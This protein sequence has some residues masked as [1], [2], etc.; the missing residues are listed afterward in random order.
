M[1]LP[2]SRTW[3]T[4]VVLLGLVAWAGPLTAA[5]QDA[6]KAKEVRRAIGVLE[7]PDAEEARRTSAAMTLADLGADAK[8]AVPALVVALKDKSPDTRLWAAVAL[9][10][11]DPKRGKDEMAVVVA[12]FDD[13]AAPL[14]PLGFL[15]FAQLRPANKDVVSGLLAL[16]KHKNLQAN[17]SGRIAMRNVG[18]AARD[19]LPLLEEALMDRQVLARVFAAAALARIDPARRAKAAPV[20]EAAL[21]DKDLD[22]RFEAA[23]ALAEIDPVRADRASAALLPALED[24]S[25]DTR[26]RVAEAIL[27]FDPPRRKDLLAALLA[28]VKEADKPDRLRALS[29]LAQMG[30]AAEDAKKT[31][32]SLLKSKEPEIGEAAAEALIRL[33]PDRART[34]FPSLLEHRSRQNPGSA[35]ADILRL[36]DGLEELSKDAGKD[37][38]KEWVDSLIEQLTQKEMRRDRDLIRLDALMRLAV[39]GPKAKDAVPALLQTLREETPLLRNQ[40]VHVL[41]GMG[42]AAREAVPVLLKVTKDRD[43][44]PLDVREAAAAAI[45]RIDPETA[46]KEGLR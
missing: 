6:D 11:I 18:P 38:E 40:T 41:A 27:R 26:L 7:N 25:V 34:I 43:G 37:K 36:V 32:R 12:L 33:Q 44:Q 9:V 39:L 24:K 17:Y 45:K 2:I 16:V 31:L 35:T 22:V 30:D 14:S 8:A 23:D 10:N 28:I 4:K 15:A 42:P 21:A 29:L 20:A 19:A 46:K 1:Q 13:D 3:I 5:D